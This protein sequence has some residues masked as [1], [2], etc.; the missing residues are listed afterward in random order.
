[1]LLD[2]YSN[3]C[4]DIRQTHRAFFIWPKVERRIE[5][6]DEYKEFCGADGFI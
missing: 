3:S 2:V 1:M 6:T 4:R 5:F